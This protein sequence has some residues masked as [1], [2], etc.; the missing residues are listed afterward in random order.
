VDAC[1]DQYN[2][3]FWHFSVSNANFRH[4]DGCVDRNVIVQDE[5]HQESLQSSGMDYSFGKAVS[6]AANEMLA[7]KVT[8]SKS[9]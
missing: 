8:Q 6:A 5:Q 4:Q 3:N 1:A 2:V 9:S 7:R